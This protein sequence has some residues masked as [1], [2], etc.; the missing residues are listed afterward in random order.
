MAEQPSQHEAHA[1]T[2]VG[3]P[4]RLWDDANAQRSG[5]CGVYVTQVLPSHRR[6]GTG[7]TSRR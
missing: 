7:V 6:I 3:R 1:L 2:V 5:Q 4:P